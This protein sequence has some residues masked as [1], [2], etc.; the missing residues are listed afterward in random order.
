MNDGHPLDLKIH[1]GT[2][3]QFE[4]FGNFHYS[5]DLTA[6]GF[7]RSE[8]LSGASLN[9]AWK[10]NGRNWGVAF[11]AFKGWF[12]QDQDHPHDTVQVERGIK[13]YN[14]IYKN[15]SNPEQESD[16][17]DPNNGLNKNGG[18]GGIT[19]ITWGCELWKFPDG[20]G[21]HYYM[22]INCNY[23]FINN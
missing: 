22:E 13:Y 21:G 20:E 11:E 23:T 1:F 2:G 18:S 10:D 7:S 12:T 4:D 16:S 19:I 14:E 9:Q 5:A 3:T 17:C 6:V 8:I 15:D